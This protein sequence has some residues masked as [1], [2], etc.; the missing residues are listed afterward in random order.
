MERRYARSNFHEYRFHNISINNELTGDH[1][2][3][4]TF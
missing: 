2:S 3:L 4:M 1:R